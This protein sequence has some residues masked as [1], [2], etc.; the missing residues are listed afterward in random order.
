MAALPDGTITFYKAK[1][2]GIVLKSQELIKCKN[3]ENY[4]PETKICEFWGSWTEEDGYCHHGMKKDG[5]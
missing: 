1:K 3:C 5:E 2:D 4:M